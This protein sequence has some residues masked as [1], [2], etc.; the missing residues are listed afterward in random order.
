MDQLS[1]DNFIYQHTPV[2]PFD[3]QLSA[4]DKLRQEWTKDHIHT[5]DPNQV[6]AYNTAHPLLRNIKVE[7]L[8]QVYDGL[9]A[10]KIIKKPLPLDFVVAVL[11]KYQCKQIN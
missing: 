1:S 3:I 7:N 11:V 4:W 2:A 6:D 5:Y 9:I 10:S 8:A